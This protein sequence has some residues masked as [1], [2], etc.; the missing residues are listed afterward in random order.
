VDEGYQTS[1]GG[2]TTLADPEEAWG[3]RWIAGSMP[4][5]RPFAGGGLMYGP[6]VILNSGR[7]FFQSPDALVPQDTNGREDVYEYEPVG[8][9]TC[10]EQSSVYS[11]AAGGCVSLISSGSSSQ[12]SVFYDASESGNDVFFSTRSK[13]AWTDLDEATDVYDARAPHVP[14]EQVGFPEPP[15]PP[16]CEG[17]ACQGTP[18][19]VI[20]QTPGSLTYEG[21]GNMPPP[22]ST[23]GTGK[24][25][26]GRCARKGRK[27]LKHG[28]CVKAARHPRA[29]KRGRAAH[30]WGG[31][32]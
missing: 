15:R 5:W 8:A 10:T 16:A 14:G 20:D 12:E 25:T 11:P 31:G 18:P 9:G 32:R 7:L 29:R 2:I 24:H 21:P 22:R 27:V 6:R 17:D 3:G 1:G 13:L 28:R 19:S 26:K 4:G 30:K 23:T